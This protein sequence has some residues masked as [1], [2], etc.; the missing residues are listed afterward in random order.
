MSVT[1]VSGLQTR[2]AFYLPVYILS[3]TFPT[4]S[5]RASEELSPGCKFKAECK[6]S[7]TRLDGQLQF[8]LIQDHKK[9]FVKDNVCKVSR[10]EDS[11]TK[12]VFWLD[13]IFEYPRGLKIS[14]RHQIRSK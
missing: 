5:E 11:K 7:S 13:P 14:V 12:I 10:K 6:A 2:L 1:N 3:L 8:F 9:G 4:R